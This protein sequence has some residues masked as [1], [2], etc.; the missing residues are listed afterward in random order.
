MY[1]EVTNIKKSDDLGNSSFFYT[2]LTKLKTGKCTVHKAA[3][4][5]K[6]MSKI[7]NVLVPQNYLTCS[8]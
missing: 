6:Y 7:P 5:E 4:T 3:W 2:R 8:L 1:S